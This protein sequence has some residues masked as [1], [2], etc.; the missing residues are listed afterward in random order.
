MKKKVFVLGLGLIGAS[1]CRAIKNPSIELFGWDHSEETRAIALEVG[2]VDQITSIREASQMD[3]II[4]AVPVLASL[5]Y[6]Q[7]LAK[8]PLKSSVIVTDTGSTKNEV[9]K[10]AKKLPFTFVGGH[11]MA[12]SH[13][14]GVKAGNPNLFEEAYYILTP[15]KESDATPLIELLNPTRAKFVVIEPAAHDEIVGMLSHLPHIVAA[16]LVRMSDHLSEKH[17]R[18]TQLAAGGFRDITRIASS[19]PQMWTD[20]LLTNRSTL[21]NL[22]EEWQNQM[23]QIKRSLLAEDQSEIYAFF[24]QAKRSRDQLPVKD[25]GAIPA[26]YDLYVDIPDIVGAIAKV[27]TILSEAKIS[28]IN[29]KIQETREDIFGVLELSFKNQ[30]DLEKGQQ[31][32]E[33]ADFHCRRRS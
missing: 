4:L 1:L 17:P 13:K 12:G 26:F 10:I 5:N 20:I 11:P 23:N 9:M 32:I 30:I 27:M 18:A 14:S 2:L 22:I 7:E 19:D 33:N 24:D 25:R 16:G 3:V 21:L 8:L 15:L 29:L 31:M 6:L 28:I